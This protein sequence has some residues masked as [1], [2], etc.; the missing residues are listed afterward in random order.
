MEKN[1]RRISWLFL[2]A[3][4]VMFVGCRDELY[5]GAYVIEEPVVSDIDSSGFTLHNYKQGHSPVRVELLGIKPIEYNPEDGTG[6]RCGKVAFEMVELFAQ[7][8]NA[9]FKLYDIKEIDKD[10][11]EAYVFVQSHNAYKEV[12]AYFIQGELLRQGWTTIDDRELPDS[13]VTKMLRQLDKEGKE[14]ERG[15][16]STNMCNDEDSKPD[17]RVR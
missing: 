11:I 1:L 13:K 2:M 9:R 10:K 17:T 4:V 15:I 8:P 3:V 6:E 7:H 12:D 16:W 14:S 5:P